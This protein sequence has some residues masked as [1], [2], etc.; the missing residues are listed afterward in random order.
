MPSL[1]RSEAILGM[2][3]AS[4]SGAAILAHTFAG[5]PM[6]LTVPFVVL[7][8]TSVLAGLI[9]LRRR[10]YRRLH[11]FA[12]LLMQGA[13]AGFLATLVYDAVRP[14][15]W[16]IFGFSFD[17]YRAMRIFGELM[18]GLPGAHWLALTCGWLYHF[19]NGISF[20]MMFALI[21]PSGGVMA[22][23]LWA[24]ALQGLMMITYPRF[25][26]ARLEDPGFLITGLVGHAL[27]GVILGARLE[28][29][30]KHA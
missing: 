11:V 16:I 23:F 5:V 2:V 30:R 15:L 26:Q 22:G 24:M 19:W 8:A 17:P 1:S 3:L 29:G 10:L 6:V 21:R 14:L 27:W 13:R 25:L 20:G 7:P 18:T 28:R 12:D 9:L 4:T